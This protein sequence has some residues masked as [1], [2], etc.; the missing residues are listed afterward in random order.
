VLRIAPGRRY[1]FCLVSRER[2]RTNGLSWV[3]LL[4]C[5]GACRIGK[6]QISSSILA[7]RN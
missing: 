5:D 6:W 7:H 2:I 1:T 4:R 3:L